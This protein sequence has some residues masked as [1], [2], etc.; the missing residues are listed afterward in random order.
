MYKRQ[1]K[2]VGEWLTCKSEPEV[3][4]FSL[5]NDTT[6]TP[7]PFDITML[8][9]P[10]SHSKASWRWFCFHFLTTPH[11]HHLL[12]TTPHSELF[13]LLHLF[14]LDSYWTPRILP[15]WTRTGTNFMLVDHHTNF[16]SQS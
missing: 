15:D 16:V 10:P 12:L 7:P 3:V 2:F 1:D 4:P 13:T 5:F 8:T 6:P 9:P 14:L 11:P